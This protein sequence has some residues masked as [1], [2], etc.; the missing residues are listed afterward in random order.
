MG[1]GWLR[2]LGEGLKKLKSRSLISAKLRSKALKL[3][4]ETC[5]ELPKMY[6]FS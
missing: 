5:P 2:I 1:M 6:L 3:P 4:V